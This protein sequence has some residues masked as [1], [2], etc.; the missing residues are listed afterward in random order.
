MDIKR[1]TINGDSKREYAKI[2]V[3]AHVACNSRFGS[4]YE[5]NVKSYLEDLDGLFREIIT[6][7]KVI[8]IDYGPDNSTAS[9]MSTWLSK[10]YFGLFYYDFA[11]TGNPE[12]RNVCETVVSSKNFEI[13]R[14]SYQQGHGFCLPSTLYAFR[15]NYAQSFDLRTTVVPGA[16]LI[17]I[18]SLVL[19]LA[20]ADGFLTKNYL[21]DAPLDT[22]RAMIRE[23]EDANA[24]FPG[25]LLS[26]AEVL[27]LRL[28]I[29]KSPSFIFSEDR[30]INMSLSTMAANPEVLYQIDED[31]LRSER[32]Q[33]Y[34]NLRISIPE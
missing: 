13:V 18:D 4:E 34:E 14:R 10:I 1:E 30:V 2:K 5:N 21:R 25:Y 3:P 19:V 24:D 23:Q 26:W 7:E 33:I 27:A 31:W 6:E 16:I 8:R 22:L 29:P 12:W 17:K 28:C 9:V 20:L 32:K 15:S 11:T